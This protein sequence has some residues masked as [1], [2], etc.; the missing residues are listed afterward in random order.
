M[1]VHC[2]SIDSRCIFQNFGIVY[3]LCL[4]SA[5]LLANAASLTGRSVVAYHVNIKVNWLPDVV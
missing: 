3:S 5:P 4:L 1:S 2:I